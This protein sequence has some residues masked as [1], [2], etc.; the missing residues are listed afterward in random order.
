MKKFYFIFPAVAVL[1]VIPG[2]YAALVRH[3]YGRF[4]FLVAWQFYATRLHIPGPDR[5]AEENSMR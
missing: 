3:G 2:N 5:R 4:S 1:A